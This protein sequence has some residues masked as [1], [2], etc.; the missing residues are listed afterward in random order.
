MGS[1]GRRISHSNS[2]HE[3]KPLTESPSKSQIAVEFAHRFKRKYPQRSVFWVHAGSEAQ[4]INNFSTI[5]ND[6]NIPRCNEK[7]LDV[8]DLVRQRLESPD[9]P[10]WLMFIDNADDLEL[11]VGKPGDQ[12]QE[13]IPQSPRQKPKPLRAY[14]P[15]C[16]HGS[17]LVTTKSKLVAVRLK[18]S[19]ETLEVPN[20]GM[21]ESIQLMRKLLKTPDD[22]ENALGEL[23]TALECLP[24]ALA[25]AAAYIQEFIQGTFKSESPVR[26]YLDMLK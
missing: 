22:Q 24:L 3:P 11:F 26:M 20:M 9:S 15:D 25:Q 14:I 8:A 2:G 12:A 10:A 5:A 19:G 17:I 6:L 16:P 7:D 18:E 21:S 4:F 13:S 1:G 23:A